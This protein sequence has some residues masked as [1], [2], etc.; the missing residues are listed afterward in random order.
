MPIPVNDAFFAL[1]HVASLREGSDVER[2]SCRS[3]VY[4]AKFE[5]NA[6]VI[7]VPSRTLPH[8]RE[9]ASFV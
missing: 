1:H 6:K 3:T 5:P 8:L 2:V 9:A 7:R 4:K